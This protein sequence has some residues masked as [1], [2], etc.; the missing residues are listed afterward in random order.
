MKRAMAEKIAKAIGGR[1][2]NTH[3]YQEIYIVLADDDHGYH[4]IISSVLVSGKDRSTEWERLYNAA[5]ELN[6][7]KKEPAEAKK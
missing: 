3:E 2:I 6:A 7:K 4:T 1:A 5:E